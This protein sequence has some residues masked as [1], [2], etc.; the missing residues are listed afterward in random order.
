MIDRILD[1][2]TGI[3]T[4]W[5]AVLSFFLPFAETVALLDLLVP[6]EVGMV[7]VGVHHGKKAEVAT[8]KTRVNAGDRA[9]VFVLPARIADAERAFAAA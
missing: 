4:I 7:V 6:G 3:D 2:L 1:D 9:I 5:L 8:G